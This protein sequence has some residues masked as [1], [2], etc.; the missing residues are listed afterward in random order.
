M[1]VQYKRYIIEQIVSRLHGDF[2]LFQRL[3]ALRQKLV[4]ETG[5]NLTMM[6]PI[7]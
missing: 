4:R 6:K 3:V 2:L 7:A 5:S 1:T